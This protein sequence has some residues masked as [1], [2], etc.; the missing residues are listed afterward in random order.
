MSS[1]IEGYLVRVKTPPDLD[2]WHLPFE[3]TW[4]LGLSPIIYATPKIHSSR[5]NYDSKFALEP[6]MDCT[7]FM[8]ESNKPS[9]I[10]MPPVMPMVETMLMSP[11]ESVRSCYRDGTLDRIVDPY[12]MG[13]IA[14]EE[15]QQNLEGNINI[16]GEALTE[17]SGDGTK[18]RR[19]CS[20]GDTSGVVFSE[21]NE[22]HARR[23]DSTAD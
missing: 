22:L 6:L 16:G 2:T 4:H 7:T 5:G 3:D 18:S 21:I 12:L 9:F 20:W 10:V 19:H 8:R 13:K 14:F 11:A 23:H 17:M 1:V 15:L